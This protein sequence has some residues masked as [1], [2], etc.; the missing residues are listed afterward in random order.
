LSVYGGD[1][2]PSLSSAHLNKIGEFNQIDSLVEYVAEI[3]LNHKNAF[4]ENGSHNPNSK[5]SHQIKHSTIKMID[6]RESTDLPFYCTTI[7]LP[8]IFKDDYKKLILKE[9]NPPPPKA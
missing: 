4:P 3:M 8:E 1:F 6:F 9:I 7:N 2:D 5:S